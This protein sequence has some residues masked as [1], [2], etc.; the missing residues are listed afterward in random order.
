MSKFDALR[1]ATAKLI[2]KQT[3]AIKLNSP[4]IL[5][6][7]GVAAVLTSGVLLVRKTLKVQPLVEDHQERVDD[8]RETPIT[9]DY[10]EK[11][12]GRDLAKTYAKSV[13]TFSMHYAP[14]VTVGLGGLACLLAANGILKQRNVALAAA[15]QTLQ[16]GVEQYRKRVAEHIGAEAEEDAWKG[17][18]RE[19]VIDA[20][21][22]E[23]RVRITHDPNGISPYARF[24]DELNPNW[25]ET[26]EYNLIFL[27]NKQSLFNDLL[28]ARG[29]VFLNDVYKELGLPQTQ[30]GQRVGWDLSHDSDGYIDFGMY[31][32]HSEAAREFVNGFERSIRL[33]FNVTGVIL[34][35]IPDV[36]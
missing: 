28:Q 35:S 4:Q 22:G 1:L 7:V 9:P 10:S 15:Y 36:I 29:C 27:R 13:G 33:D 12:R 21:T 18:K 3:E 19:E 14:A 30:A 23:K 8:I 20:E 24:F 25:T 17:I 6:G 32:I 2:G 31:D 26:P 34:G 16:K 11:D 5:T